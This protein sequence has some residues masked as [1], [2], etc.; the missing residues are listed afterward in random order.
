MGLPR[1]PS[2]HRFADR[3]EAGKDL[4]H[5][6]L[7]VTAAIPPDQLVVLG[8]ARGGVVVAAEV[9]HRLGCTL[10]TCVVRKIG[11]PMQPELA[12]GAVAPG[13][14]RVHNRT[15]IR[16]L[17]LDD[18]TVSALTERAEADRNR[19]ETVLRGSKSPAL[20]AGQT[21]ILVDDGLATGATMRAALTW[22]L[23]SARSII[24]AV[25]TASPDIVGAFEAEGVRVVSLVTPRRFG[26]VGN[27]Y[28]RFEEVSS[29]RVRALLTNAEDAP[30]H[31]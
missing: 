13:G 11:S 17:E 6:L 5:A 23:Q 9:A 28:E 2:Q 14:V 21:V 31:E 27:S 25:P 12:I 16:E 30:D 19:L 24:I 4:G 22:A 26:S 8:L 15:L 18:A 1:F 29:E 7:A 3:T 20:L 10:D